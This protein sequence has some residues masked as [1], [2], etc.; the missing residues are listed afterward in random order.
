M[1]EFEQQNAALRNRILKRFCDTVQ[2]A[3]NNRVLELEACIRI[4]SVWRR[5]VVCKNLRRLQYVIY[6]RTTMTL[7]IIFVLLV[8]EVR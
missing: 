7:H 1:S 3:E 8:P 6:I 5:H 4:Q 2:D